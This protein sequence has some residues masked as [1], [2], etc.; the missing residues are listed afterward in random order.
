[1]TAATR[2]LSLEETLLEPPALSPPPTR[3]ALFAI[4]IALAALLHVATIGSGDLYSE[5]EGQYAGAAREMVESHQWLLPTND[6]IPRLQKPPLLYWLIIASFKLFGVNTAAARLPVA[7]A[8]VASVALI[9]LIGEK[10]T[11]Y[12][13]GFI[14]GLIYLSF[15]GTFLLARIVMPEPLVSAFIAG[16]IF[17]AVCGYQRRQRRRAWFAGFWICSAF[18][19]LTKGLLGIL[20]PAAIL[21]L[22][23]IF[24]REARLRYRA[25]LRWEYVA[26]FLLIVAPW[27]IW[28]E[29]HFPG[30][31]RYQITSEWMGHLRGLFDAT[32]DFKG[33]SAYQFLVM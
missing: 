26:I 1:M 22:L 3:H 13:H 25:V 30:Y 4:L 24:Y 21:V 28:A 31:F 7:L 15:L 32:H 10:L 11:D 19:C 20:Y 18:A 27:H 6:G 9:F 23:S 29:W 8:V 33:I 5:T 16:A 2:S 14:A 12:W 17:C